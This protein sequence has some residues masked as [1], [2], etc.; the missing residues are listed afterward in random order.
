[1][2]IGP[3]ALSEIKNAL[4][5]YEQKTLGPSVFLNYTDPPKDYADLDAALV[6]AHKL[7]H[8]LSRIPCVD[9]MVVPDNSI[10]NE[11]L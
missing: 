11:F 3:L 6:V 10:L 9:P 7:V 4:L 2:V 8:D 5:L 1:M